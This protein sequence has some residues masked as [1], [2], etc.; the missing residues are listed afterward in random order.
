VEDY[1]APTYGDRIADVYDDWY[2]NLDPGPAAAFLAELAGDGRALELAIGTGRIA[3]PL[4]TRGVEVDGIDA[5]E[6][7]VERLR[8]KPAAT[9]SP[10]PSATSRTSGPRARS[11]SSTS[12]STRSSRCASRR[13]RCAASPMSPRTSTR[14]DARESGPRGVGYFP[15]A[16]TCARERE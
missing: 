2:A 1:D 16:A 15:H 4:T 3:L 11:A 12:P 8:A 5:S 9:R 14:R 6:R 13:R 10:S 7:M